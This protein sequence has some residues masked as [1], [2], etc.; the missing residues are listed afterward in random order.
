MSFDH[1][2]IKCRKLT[3]HKIVED[4]AYEC[5]ECGTL[6]KRM[7]SPNRIPGIGNIT[8]VTED[9]GKEHLSKEIIEEVITIPFLPDLDEVYEEPAPPPTKESGIGIFV[10]PLPEE[11]RNQKVKSMDKT[12]SPLTTFLK[13]IK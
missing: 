4:F 5:V 1:M 13:S 3:D 6:N 12:E 2:C 10:P 8:E 9:Y 11:G 7:A